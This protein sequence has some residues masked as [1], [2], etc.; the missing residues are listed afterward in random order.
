MII[1]FGAK[2][3]VSVNWNNIINTFK[4]Y[5]KLVKFTDFWE[6]NPFKLTE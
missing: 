5:I 1:G 6:E 3:I 4:N 2:Q